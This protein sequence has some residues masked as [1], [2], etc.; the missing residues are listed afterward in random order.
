MSGL[1]GAAGGIRRA[2]ELAFGTLARWRSGR[3]VHTRGVELD[4]TLTLDPG[5]AIGRILGEPWSRPAV[6]RA[7]KS[8]G[9]PGRRADLLGMAVRI[10]VGGGVFDVLLASTGRRGLGHQALLPSR[11]WWGR[12]YSTILPY[13]ADGTSVLLG[14]EAQP[15]PTRLRPT[16]PHP[17][18][19][20]PE[21]PGA[22]PAELAAA[23]RAGPIGLEVTAMR[24]GGRRRPIGRLVLQRVR[25]DPPPIAYDPIRNALPRLRP[26]RLL[27]SVREWAYT[28]SRRGRAAD[29]ASLQRRP[30]WP[31]RGR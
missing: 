20:H 19:P 13:R 30:A 3:A 6:V 16:L 28:G 31:A 22:D 9:L 11:T 7:S 5:T 23:V 1:P 14:L 18:Q 26:S 12:P 8:V 15:R 27:A 29:P 17:A 21:Q 25:E 10:P 2:V 4:A 24:L